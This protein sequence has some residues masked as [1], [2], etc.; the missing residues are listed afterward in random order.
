ME[1]PLRMPL[2]PVRGPAEAETH[3]VITDLERQLELKLM[4]SC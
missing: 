3:S 1:L 4:A 2:F